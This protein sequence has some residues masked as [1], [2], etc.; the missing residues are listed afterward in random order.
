[1]TLDTQLAVRLQQLLDLEPSLALELGKADTTGQA[2]QLIT[3]AGAQHGVSFDELSLSRLLEALDGA[4]TAGELTDDQL[5][6][7]DGGMTRAQRFSSLSDVARL[8]P[9]EYHRQ[10]TKALNHVIKLYD[11]TRPR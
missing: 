2:V 11:E 10:L 3:A 8:G 5:I 6:G 4:A 9:E 7:V 1:M